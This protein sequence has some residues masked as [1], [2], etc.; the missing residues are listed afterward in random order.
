MN[1]PNCGAFNPPDALFCSTCGTTF[2]AA[3]GKP[4][5]ALFK[6][7]PKKTAYPPYGYGMSQQPPAGG[8]TGMPPT[9]VASSFAQPSAAG[10][11][12]ASAMTPP[13]DTAGAVSGGTQT[14]TSAASPYAPPAA[15]TYTPYSPATAPDP[16]AAYGGYGSYTP[17]PGFPPVKKGDRKKDWAAITGLILGI[18][19]IGCCLFPVWFVFFDIPFWTPILFT[20]PGI[21]LSIIG[22]KSTKKGLSIAGLCCAALGFLITLYMVLYIAADPQY[23]KDLYE[24]AL[25][26]VGGG[27]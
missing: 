27:Y 5:N 21:A 9:P 3:S 26:E 10:T 1:C 22:I 8:Y 11:D 20:L 13:Q 16:S 7:R 6:D 19:S 14:P 18:L 25:Q 15:A 2:N 23:I 12:P 17:G 4:E 24:Q